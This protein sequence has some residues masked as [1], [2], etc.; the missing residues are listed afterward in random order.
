[1]HTLNHFLL[2][3]VLTANCLPAFAQDWI[4]QAIYYDSNNHP[5]KMEQEYK[6]SADNTTMYV[7]HFSDRSV[8]KKMQTFRHGDTTMVEEGY[9]FVATPFSH[10]QSLVACDQIIT[11]KNITGD[12]AILTFE[13]DAYSDTAYEFHTTLIIGD[14]TLYGEEAENPT[15]FIEKL[16]QIR[17][18]E[19]LE[20]KIK[21]SMDSMRLQETYRTYYLNNLP[22][23]LEVYGWNRKPSLTK[24]CQLSP[25]KMIWYSTFI[26]DSGPSELFA[27][28]IFTWNNDTSQITAHFNRFDDVKWDDTAQYYIKGDTLE[29]SYSGGHNCTKVL[30]KEHNVLGKVLND[31]VI[32]ED[33]AWT[34]E[35]YNFE[36]WRFVSLQSSEGLVSNQFVYDDKHRVVE[37]N[38]FFN[39]TLTKRVVYSYAK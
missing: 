7:T 37:Q 32:H 13:K 33:P 35:L 18:S 20:G 28:D 24:T 3:L 17:V 4:V 27:I 10:I 23:R 39:N 38:S 34:E 25:N 16:K 15:T 22:I 11:T 8:A 12:T 36:N 5:Y 19:I 6:D 26:N 29:T 2:L 21:V 14:T 30:D 1:M 31:H 9:Y